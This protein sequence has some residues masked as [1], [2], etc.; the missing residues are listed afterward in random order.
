[1]F[2]EQLAE[3][4]GI[5]DLRKR[6]LPGRVWPT[7]T[8]SRRE[9]VRRWKGK[10]EEM[11]R[12]RREGEEEKQLWEQQV[13]RERV[14]VRNQSEVCIFQIQNFKA[15]SS[16]GLFLFQ[17]L[18]DSYPVLAPI[19]KAGRMNLRRGGDTVVI[20]GS[21]TTPPLVTSGNEAEIDEV[22]SEDDDISNDVRGR[23]EEEKKEE[24]RRSADTPVPPR[25][26]K[27]VIW[28]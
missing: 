17:D 22:E 13:W 9:E 3:T 14:K 7:E 2:L 26:T 28:T 21:Q 23:D 27:A 10:E 19:R 16:Q 12:I 1:M 24:C 18:N 8:D 6:S 20:H 25:F 4:V 15:E 5:F 11:V